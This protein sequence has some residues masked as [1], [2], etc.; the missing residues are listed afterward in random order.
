MNNKPIAKWTSLL[1]AA[2]LLI[3]GLFPGTV[4]TAAA[5]PLPGE[6]LTTVDAAAVPYAGQW[7][8][9]TT[10]TAFTFTGSMWWSDAWSWMYDN[11]ANANEAVTFHFTGD[12]VAL[13]MTKHDH[14]GIVNIYV[15]DALKTTV[16]TV[17]PTWVESAKVFEQTGLSM[18]AHTLKV[19]VAGKSVATD[20]Y[21]LIKSFVYGTPP[22]A[23]LT[24]PP[25]A[26]ANHTLV[27]AAA[28]PNGGQW[29]GNAAQTA[30]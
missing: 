22:S 26:A 14:G 24:P 11:V 21:V 27:D 13:N 29:T 17:N 5:D 28:V 18:G 9:N 1:L 2:V 8:G 20:A 25:A 16:D 4:R 15:D 19:E 10:Q 23:D 6:I 30:F 3:A 12:Y 7:T